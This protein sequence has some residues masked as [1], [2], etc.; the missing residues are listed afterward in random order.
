MVHQ[1]HDG[2]LA[3]ML[4]SE[5]SSKAFSGTNSVKQSCVLSPTLFSMMFTAMLNDAFQDSDA[6][7]RL[8]YR[9]NGK[10]HSVVHCVGMLTNQLSNKTGLQSHDTYYPSVGL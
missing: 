7:V 9:V 4:D 3:R 2:M 1:F 6:G 5:E 10:L 8:K